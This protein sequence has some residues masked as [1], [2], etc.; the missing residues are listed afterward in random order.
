MLSG[1]HMPLISTYCC[2]IYLSE[3]LT[4]HLLSQT[5]ALF[6][7]Q[8]D[9]TPSVPSTYTVND[10]FLGFMEAERSVPSPR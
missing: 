6:R 4:L 9:H 10:S 1:L 7:R 8:M 5:E 2:L 3:G